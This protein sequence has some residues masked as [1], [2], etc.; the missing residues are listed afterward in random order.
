MTTTASAHLDAASAAYAGFSPATQQAVDQAI[1][2]IVAA[3]K[4]C[5]KV[6]AITGSG[7][8][9]HEGVTTLIAELMH[10]GIIDGVITSSAV[11]SHEMAG[12]L[13]RVKRVPAAK[14]PKIPPGIICQF[15]EADLLGEE[16]LE[17]CRGEFAVDEEYYRMLLAAEGDTIIKA[18]GNL[19][20]PGGLRSELAAG[21]ILAVCR[22]EQKPFEE[23]AGRIA[24]PM[25]ML[26]AGAILGKPVLV[27]VPQ[28]V[29]GGKVG[30]A[31][32]DSIPISERS[33]RVARLLDQAEVLVES[34]I[35]LCQEIHD[36]PFETFT[37]H[38]LWS[39]W[40]GEWS[41]SLA[42]KTLIRID[43]DE[44]LQRICDRESRQSEISQAVNRGLPKAKSTG[45]PFRMEMSGFARHP[46]SLPIIGDIGQV[47]PVIA[48][49]VADQLGI[50][51]NFFSANQG[52]PAGQE[53]R[54]WIVDHVQPLG[55]LRG[56]STPA[57]GGEAPH[58]EESPACGTGKPH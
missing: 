55:D 12:T 20:Y 50:R 9:L 54:R 53:M 49:R 57:A 1:A 17:R 28:L 4:H 21:K 36:G 42:E 32:G 33:A 19:A 16:W 23:I 46:K 18:A 38:G 41:F 22:E 14:M 15:Y 56:L 25:T 24:D 47:W 44:N 40:Q 3:K 2:A 45:I 39:A 5:G 30:L 37:G 34:A 48:A 27:S 13:E 8:N 11:V 26:G 58:R 43:L 51:L 10:R 52:S 31:I 7:P 29:G 6:V 35:A